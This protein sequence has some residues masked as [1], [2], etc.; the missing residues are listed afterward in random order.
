MTNNKNRRVEKTP[1]KQELYRVSKSSIEEFIDE[2]RRF[3]ELDKLREVQDQKR[4]Y[5]RTMIYC[6]FLNLLFVT[7]AIVGLKG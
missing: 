3:D 2:E 1:S 4:T 6:I 7:L 5:K